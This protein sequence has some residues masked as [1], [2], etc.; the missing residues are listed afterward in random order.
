MII[1]KEKQNS[2]KLQRKVTL[3][4]CSISNKKHITLFYTLFVESSK[5]VSSKFLAAINKVIKFQYLKS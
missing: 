4:P 3:S 1:E 2:F 5:Q